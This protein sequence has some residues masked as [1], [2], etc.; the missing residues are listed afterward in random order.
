MPPGWCLRFAYGLRYHSTNNRSS[1]WDGSKFEGEYAAGSV[2][3]G[4]TLPRT[5]DDVFCRFDPESRGG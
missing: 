2:Q 3:P 1:P 5:F 4:V